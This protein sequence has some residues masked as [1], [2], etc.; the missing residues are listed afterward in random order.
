MNAKGVMKWRCAEFKLRDP[1]PPGRVGGTG[2]LL[3]VPNPLPALMRVQRGGQKRHSLG[4]SGSFLLI[5]P[6][7]TGRAV[8]FL[9]QFPIQD[10]LVFGRGPRLARP[11]PS[12]GLIR[13][14]LVVHHRLEHLNG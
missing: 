6:P 4:C 14:A 9:P 5:G 13:D 2:P 8:L 12:R 11:K 7:S 3:W 10:P 1:F